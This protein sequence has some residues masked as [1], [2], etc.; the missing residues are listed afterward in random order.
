MRAGRLSSARAVVGLAVA[1]SLGGC[2]TV[3]ITAADPNAR[4]FAGGR[5]LGR[6][7]GEI[8]RRGMPGSTIIVAVSEDGRRSQT[9]ARREFTAFTFVTGLFTYGICMFACWEYPSDVVVPLAAQPASEALGARRMDAQQM[10][11]LWL[12][13]P[14]G[15]T[16]R[17][18][19]P[20]AGPT[21]PAAPTPPQ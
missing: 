5:S 21:P 16:P 10:D 8:S 3:R 12:N 13:P 18:K 11:A 17:S 4:L 2:G 6:G 9:I 1:I 19:A 14:P 15:W 7:T 20:A